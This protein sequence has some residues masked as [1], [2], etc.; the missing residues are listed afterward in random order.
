MFQKSRNYTLSQGVKSPSIAVFRDSTLTQVLYH[1]T[2]VLQEEGGHVRINTGGWDTVSTR[3][4]INR[5]LDQIPGKDAALVRE[6]GVT[7]LYLDGS[8][9]P[10]D[11]EAR[12]IKVRGA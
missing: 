5:A 3:I 12:F 2:I 7:W 1:R 4:V 9:L 6:K 11:G 8:R 10:F